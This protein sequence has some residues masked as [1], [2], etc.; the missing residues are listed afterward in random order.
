MSIALD[1]G[2]LRG[3]I[4]VFVFSA[5][6][7]LVWWAWSGRRRFDFDAAAH[8]PLENDAVVAGAAE[9]AKEACHD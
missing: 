9:L 8:L 6:M 4:T 2:L 7:G 1:L 5:F 3:L